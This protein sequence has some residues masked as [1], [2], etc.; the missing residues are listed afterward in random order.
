MGNSLVFTSVFAVF[1]TFFSPTY[2]DQAIESDYGS[3][4]LN[5]LCTALSLH[6]EKSD[7]DYV[8]GV[9]VDGRPVVS[10]DLNAAPQVDFERV[11]IPI[12][13]DLAERFDIGFTSGLDAEALVGVLHLDG[14]VLYFND[15]KI[16][17]AQSHAIAAE[18]AERRKSR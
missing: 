18:C 13:V 3:H 10:A 15:Q 6:D 2:A 12:T 5:Q 1:S 11:Y 7:A 4:N 9:D 8:E 16:S 14:D 17:D